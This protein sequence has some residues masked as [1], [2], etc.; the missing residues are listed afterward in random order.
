[1]ADLATILNNHVIKMVDTQ[2]LI[3]SRITSKRSYTASD[4]SATRQS[5][6]KKRKELLELKSSPSFNSKAIID[7]Q[8]E[9]EALENGIARLEAL[10]KEL[11]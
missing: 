1:M 8:I 6:N 4:I 11:F 10:Q 5:L 2:L 9:V 7:A 3:T